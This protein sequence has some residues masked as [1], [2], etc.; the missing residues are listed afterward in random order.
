M[1]GLKPDTV[2]LLR[3]CAVNE[4]GTRAGENSREGPGPQESPRNRGDPPVHGTHGLPE[5]GLPGPRK[6]KSHVSQEGKGEVS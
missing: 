3:V 2:Y 4:A 1:Q 5:T 6:V